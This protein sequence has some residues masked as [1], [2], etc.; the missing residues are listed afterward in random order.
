MGGQRLRE[1]GW[2][3]GGEGRGSL[4]LGPCDVVG[5]ERGS[6]RAVRLRWLRASLRLAPLPQPLHRPPPRLHCGPARACGMAVQVASLLVLAHLRRL[7]RRCC[8]A[9]RMSA[10]EREAAAD[11]L[12]H[13]DRL[14]ALAR[15]SKE[16][17]GCIWDR[18]DRREGAREGH[19]WRVGAG[20]SAVGEWQKW[21]QLVGEV[22]EGRSAGCWECS[23]RGCIC[24]C[25]CACPST[26]AA[27]RSPDVQS[28]LALRPTR[29]FHVGRCRKSVGS[30]G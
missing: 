17:S 5:R 6:R 10:G 19:C 22:D 12:T 15:H 16:R 1:S 2:G 20:C 21:L 24:S 27:V 13:R 7:R 8:E 28:S 11:V 29:R 4:L 23:E 30:I 3:G 26:V 25:S 18:G 14:S 9:L